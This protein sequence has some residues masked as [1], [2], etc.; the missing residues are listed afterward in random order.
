MKLYKLTLNCNPEQL[1]GLESIKTYFEKITQIKTEYVLSKRTNNAFSIKRGDKLGFSSTLYSKKA[2]E[3]L[4]RLSKLEISENA[5]SKFG[6]CDIGVQ[7]YTQIKLPFNPDLPA[8][9][10]GVQFVVSNIGYGVRFRRRL[11]CKPLVVDKQKVLDFLQENYE[12]S[13]KR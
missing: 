1:S 8:F 9:G 13:K 12:I 10:F 3:F 11:P 6:K 5:I 7:E 2:I 4:K